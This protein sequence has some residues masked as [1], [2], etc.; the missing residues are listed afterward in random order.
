MDPDWYY[1]HLMLPSSARLNANQSR[2]SMVAEAAEAAEVTRRQLTW[3]A[4]SGEHVLHRLHACAPMQ[5]ATCGRGSSDHAA[6]YAKHLIET[7]IRLPVMSHSPST[8]SIYEV[9]LAGLERTLFLVISQSGRSSD[10]LLSAD[11][12]KVSG[13]LVCAIVNDECSPL[14]DIADITIPLL[15]GTETSVAA[16]KTY[17]ASLFTV[18]MLVGSWAKESGLLEAASRTPNLLTEAWAMDWS[19]GTATLTQARNM[20]IIGRGPT[21]GIAQE[22]ALKLKETCG[23]HAEAFSE[24]EV[25]H[26]P[27]ELVKKDF[28]VLLFV[29]GDRA[30]TGF[31]SLVDD[32]VGRGAQVI[33]AGAS[34]P[35]TVQLP[36]VAHVRAEVSAIC[37][38]QSF[39]RMAAQISVA[40]GLDP[41]RPAHLRKVTDTL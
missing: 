33:V 41:D 3:W 22:A 16:T 2:T 15:A 31:C 36:T 13:A 9:E 8:S 5:V 40:R 25:R 20:Y 37:M 6:S 38:I 10:I 26:G 14:A 21:F 7:V 4:D 23:I 19:E 27:M 24:A 29:P 11:A 30:S 28:P 32:F 12:A 34:Y 18:L 17:I 1:N 39:Y 35:G